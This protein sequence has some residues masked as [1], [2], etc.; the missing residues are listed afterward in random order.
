MKRSVD[1]PQL[2]SFLQLSDIESLVK[3]KD[4]PLITS[5]PAFFQIKVQLRPCPPNFVPSSHFLSS[6]CFSL[7][8]TQVTWLLSLHLRCWSLPVLFGKFSHLS[9]CRVLS[10]W[11]QRPLVCPVFEAD[12][13]IFLCS[14]LPTASLWF[15]LDF[16]WR[17]FDPYLPLIA[18]VVVFSLLQLQFPLILG[19]IQ[20]ICCIG[21]CDQWKRSVLPKLWSNNGNLLLLSESVIGSAGLA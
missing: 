6:V 20:P 19:N 11:P 13:E 8:L 15:L 9:D 14:F 12:L 4:P 17:R 5:F 1:E 7:N 16:Q 3:A 21:K 2:Q 18:P 10:H